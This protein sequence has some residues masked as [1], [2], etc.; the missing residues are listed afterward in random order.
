MG[1][2][3]ETR[4]DNWTTPY[5]QNPQ[6][7]PCLDILKYGKMSTNLHEKECHHFIQNLLTKD[8]QLTLQYYTM[9]IDYSYSKQWHIEYVCNIC[10]VTSIEALLRAVERP[11]AAST[12][13]MAFK[14]RTELLL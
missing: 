11:V 14:V 1:G 10:N 12:S 2:V 13:R 4:T 8:P 7:N 5:S 9:Q 3:R 6:K